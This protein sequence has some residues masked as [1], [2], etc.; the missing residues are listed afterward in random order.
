MVTFYVL[1]RKKDVLGNDAFA[2]QST[3]LDAN[4]F[5]EIFTDNTDTLLTSS[6]QVV[7]SGTLTHDYRPDTSYGDSLIRFVNTASTAAV[8]EVGLAINPSSPPQTQFFTIPKRQ[9][10][11]DGV[12]QVS[13]HDT[14]TSD[15]SINDVIEIQVKEDTTT[16]AVT[17]NGV[18]TAT[19]LTVVQTANLQNAVQATRSLSSPA[20]V[21]T[22][23]YFILNAGGIYQLQD[24]GTVYNQY[25]PYAI[26]LFN[27]SDE[28]VIVT[29]Q[30]GESI[31]APS[32]LQNNYDLLPGE[33]AEFQPYSNNVWAVKRATYNLETTRVILNGTATTPELFDV[34]PQIAVSQVIDLPYPIANIT[35]TAFMNVDAVNRR[36]VFGLYIDG[37]LRGQLVDVEHKDVSNQV[38]YTFVLEREIITLGVHTVEIRYGKR[39]GGGGAAV[40]LIDPKVLFEAWR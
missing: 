9:G 40:T 32:G 24:A 26:S 8:V 14:F 22:N 2:F 12:R 39:G 38:P 31:H 29:P 5:T 3:P 20:T 37:A 36:G 10:G 6:L 35:V 25:K 27:A 19:K 13:M 16:G 23:S 33:S 1:L 30:G 11:V 17:V 28:V 34:N 7:L 21:D 18:D 15:L 4:E